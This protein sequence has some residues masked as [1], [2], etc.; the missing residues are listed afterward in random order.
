MVPKELRLDGKLVLITGSQL[1]LV[2]ELALSLAQAG[3][4]ICITGAPK[5]TVTDLALK[6]RKEGGEALGI[7]AVP[8]N[9]DEVRRAVEETIS[10]FGKIDI[11][12]N[13]FNLELWKPLLN[14]KEE[15]WHKVLE[16]NLTSTF[17]WTQSVGKTMV[18]QQKG[19]IINVISGLAERGVINGAAYCASLG[20]I[21]QLTRALALE[22]A[23]YNVR[24]N[25]VGVGWMER[26]V[27]VGEK[28]QM[29]KYIPMRRRARPQDITPILLLLSSE[30]TSY[31]SGSI[32]HVD[33]GL[34]AR[35]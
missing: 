22:W 19:S 33:G 31:C 17:L 15:E 20:G 25:A 6:V 26:P 3:A 2:N 16:S 28:D 8:T 10:R 30:A 9:K 18:A 32:Y 34:M 35:G 24:V 21:L 4:K 13:S 27:L 23:Q 7:P 5:S 11:L 29:T 1:A 14:L 12:V